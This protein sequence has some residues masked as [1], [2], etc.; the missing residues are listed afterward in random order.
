MAARLSDDIAISGDRHIGEWLPIRFVA[1]EKLD[2][3]G[4]PAVWL[5]TRRP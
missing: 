3:K 2:V 5:A 1:V 4:K